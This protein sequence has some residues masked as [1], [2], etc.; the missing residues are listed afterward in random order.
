MGIA[1]TAAIIGTGLSAYQTV[2]A[3]KQKKEAREA[4][5]NSQR[6]EL[7]N[8]NKDIQISTLGADQMTKANNINVA[9]SVDALQRAGDR[10]VLGGIP[11]V[12]ESSVLLQD[13]ISKSLDEQ[14]AQRSQLIARGE[15]NINNMMELR[16]REALAGLGAMYNAA[17]Q[18]LVTGL[19][20]FASSALTAGKGIDEYFKNKG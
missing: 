18:N 16:E 3:A 13:Q 11:K 1:T 6:R 7:S 9:T 20:D 8:P 17:N 19:G 14:A 12:N 4:I 15:E 5:E 10:A 2:D